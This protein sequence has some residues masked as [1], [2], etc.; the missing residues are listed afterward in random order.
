MVF[1]QEI[2]NGGN[3]RWGWPMPDKRNWMYGMGESHDVN[4]N[5]CSSL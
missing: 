2:F 4:L 1:F 3:Q 5:L